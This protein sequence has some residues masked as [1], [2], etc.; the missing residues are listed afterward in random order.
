MGA[1]VHPADTSAARQKRRAKPPSSILVAFSG[2]AVAMMHAVPIGLVQVA[3]YASDVGV[4]W[5]FFTNAQTA[6]DAADDQ[7]AQAN[8]TTN[9]TQQD[10]LLAASRLAAALD[11][12]GTPDSGRA[13][14]VPEHG[15]VCTSPL[16]AE[17]V[18]W[19]SG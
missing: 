1:S 12:L 3:D 10:D 9:L 5:T 13:V 19:A 15:G 2:M 6:A 14:R 11:A 8:A 7:R 4:V 17:R 18:A 16:R